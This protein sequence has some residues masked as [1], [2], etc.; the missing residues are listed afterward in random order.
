MIKA[1]F[2]SAFTIVELI[3]VISVIAILAG[4]ILVSYGAWR[5]STATSSLK[6]DLEHAASQTESYR[7]FN[8]TY[9]VPFTLINFTPS[10]N[11]TITPTYLDS[12]SF[13][14]D[15]TTTISSSV[16]YYIDNLTQANGATSG[17]CAARAS[18]PIP[19]VVANVAFTTGSTQIS[20]SWSLAVPNYATQY[21]AQCALDPAF[22][23]GLLQ[24]TVTGAAT[25]SA[26]LSGANPVT[27]YYCRVRA[28]NTN[29]QSDWSG[30]GS[31]N[32]QQRT[33]ADSQQYGTYPDCY[34]YDSLPVGTS[35][36]GYWTTPPD[37]Y[38]LEDGSAV[39]R[40]TYADLYNLIG[41]TY[42]AGDGS[43]TFNIPDSRGRATVG[44][45]STDAEFN[46]I[47]EKYG[48]KSHTITLNE[49]PS[50]SHAQNVSANSGGSAIRNDYSSDGAGGSYA[51]GV[52]TN[53]AGGGAASNVI[54][55]SIVKQYAIKY[56][57]STGASSTL[58]P[59][60][61]LQGYWSTIPTGYLAETGATISRTT[62]SDLFGAISTTY[63]AGNG[64]T[65]FG[66]PNSQG[67]VGVEKNASDTQFATLG[68]TFGEKTHLLTI[69]EMVPHSH[70]E[71]ITANSGGSG[72]RNDY[73]A[74]AAGGVY[75]QGTNTGP[76]GGG[77]AF[78]V[79]QPS[80]AKTS[81]LKTAA[82]TGTND[83]SGMIPGTSIEGWWAT[84]PSG[85]L[86]EDGSAVSRTTYS[87][88]FALIG[89][90]YGSGDG[91]TTFNLPDARGRVAVNKNA[92]D[93][94]FATIG[95]KFGEKTH[96]MTLS[97]LPVH[98]HAQYVTNPLA[99]G[100]A[101]RN[102]YKADAAGGSYGQ[103]ISTN[104]TGGGAAYNVIQPSITKMF[105]I[106][107]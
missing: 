96:I 11:N 8:S 92:S 35:I 37:E 91:S 78:N 18:L 61:T 67:R 58:A 27:T 25:T 95:Q 33:C 74:D 20:V 102:D 7:T 100:S 89:T 101:I 73:A 42:G 93:T 17:T 30:G 28:L 77:Q 107:Y 98:S 103:N 10:A 85:F 63:G 105:A 32:T 94:Q 54:Q 76:A 9:P 4:I 39:S 5:T 48:E 45:S 53:G 59:G 3:V 64:T 88:L 99:G 81:T 16:K 34:D 68:Q 75:A 69:G 43:T 26:S 21:L 22:I 60:T 83:D 36:A 66:T 2:R 87:D 41:T 84:A 47:G 1:K 40:T 31:G 82:A 104:G 70:V 49:I 72:V 86:L 50:H 24:A 51:Q 52:N 46:S 13:C 106:K 23:T 55:P 44:L 57:P 14:L 90:T 19:G 56:R 62:Y 79:I 6:S 38:L 80:I 12:K 15:G 97:E 71:I 65:T 29:G